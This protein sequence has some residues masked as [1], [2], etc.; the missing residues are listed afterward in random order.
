M[1]KLKSLKNESGFTL[2]EMFIVIILICVLLVIILSAYTG[3][4]TKSR[5]STRE[6]NITILHQALEQYYTNNNKYPTL[7]QLNDANWIMDNMKYLSLSALKDPNGKNE[8]LSFYPTKNKFAYTVTS[9][10][11]AECNNKDV[12]CGQYILT[13][14]LE[15]GGKFTASSLN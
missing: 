15:S 13:A 9:I 10:S 11:G 1:F 2:I 5:N 6:K 4:A 3:V 12:I 7:A 14:V 8:T